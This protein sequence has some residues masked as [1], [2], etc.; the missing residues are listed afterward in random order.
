MFIKKRGDCEEARCIVSYVNNKIEG[1][2][3]NPPN[4]I[5]YDLHQTVY[6]L[7]DRFFKNEEMI[8]VSAKELLGLVTKMSSFDVDMSQI[9]RNLGEFAKEIAEL[10]ES[11]LAIV[12]ETTASMNVVSESITTSAS[13]LEQLA[14]S[15]ETLVESNNNGL[16]ELSE[17]T[18]LKENVMHNS[19]IMS[20]KI[21]ELVELTNKVNEIVNSVGTI[22]EQTNLLALNASIEAA[23]AGENGKGFAVVALEIRKLAD[24]TKRSLEGMGVFMANIQT[25]AV[26]GRESM[27]NTLDSTSKMSSKIEEVN[28]TMHNNM[29][30]LNRTI[31]DVRTVN[32]TMTEVSVSTNEIN[33][34]MESSSSD[35]QRLNYMTQTILDDSK[36]SA[37]LSKQIMKFD[38]DLSEVTKNLY[39]SLRGG[40]HI[41]TNEELKA[42]LNRAR[43]AHI[44]WMSTLNKIIEEEKLYPLQINSK[45]CAFGHF[46]HTITVDHPSI[47]DDWNAI[48]EVHNR[49]HTCGH[50]V[51]EA[52]KN[53]KKEEAMK[54]F[55]EAK[56]L[57]KHIFD[58]MDKINNE[59]D[60]QTQK[61][62]KLLS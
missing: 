56:E 20:S 51:I 7:F 19:A 60:V 1:K 12:E 36:Y 61:G 22:A 35:A 58:L 37:D 47:K 57:S 11:N 15:S 13:T 3:V 10:S 14:K 34:A 55:A 31:A 44:G 53:S 4:R 50:E 26:N 40:H 29:E 43:E 33:L 28:A 23:R 49:F 45:K 52:L 32:T 21:E 2:E 38:D 27:E 18:I 62:V 25:A 39:D 6:E 42:T 24:D 9:S 46:Y 30:L 54:Y 41:V 16:K 5:K 17:I 59:I 8:S 48:D